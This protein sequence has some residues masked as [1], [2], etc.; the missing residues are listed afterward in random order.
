MSE[1]EKTPRNKVKRIPKRGHYDAAT[2]YGIL[3]EAFVCHVGFVLDGQPFVIP[4][5]Y[6]RE[7]DVIYLHGATTSRMMKA[8]ET[9]MP[10][11]ITVTHLDGIVLARSLFNSSMNYRSAVVFGTATLVPDEKKNHALLVVSEQI[12]KDRWEEA[13]LP[14]AKELKATSV[15][16]VKIDSAS[17]KIRE[18]APG[19]DKA[20][21]DLSVWAGVMPM[22]TV[23][24]APIVDPAMRME[25]PIPES[26]KKEM[27]RKEK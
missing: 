24:D 14:T 17:A 20:D 1:F 3:D 21:Y 23:F 11:C 26:V 8:L 15:L 9:G 12:L 19:D 18:G 16:A 6:G 4:T 10:V 27:R 2:I 22:R 5:A 13:R 25:I 7:G